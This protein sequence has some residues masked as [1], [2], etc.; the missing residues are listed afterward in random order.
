MRFVVLAP[1][2]MV[3]RPL[4]M[5]EE[6]LEKK[7]DGSVRKPVESKVEVAEPPKY[8]VSKTERRVVEA[9]VND[10]RP[11]SESVPAES[12]PKLPVLA[13]AVVDVAVAKYPIPLEVKLVVLAPPFAVK[14]PEATVED[15]CARKPDG[16]VRKPVESNVLVAEPPKYALS[17]MEKRV[18]EAWVK[19]ERPV[20]ERVPAFSVP[21]LP[22]LAFA[23]VDVAVA[24]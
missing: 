17:K 22:V 24:K 1:P 13:F 4:V 14:R 5:V 3:K 21:K 20:S 12:V 7:P 6:A 10:A 19:V 9:W 2:D 15:A 16:S 18:V 8:A 23:V 11:V